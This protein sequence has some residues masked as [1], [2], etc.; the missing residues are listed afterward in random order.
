MVRQPC[1]VCNAVQIYK[2]VYHET[3]TSNGSIVLLMAILS[4]KPKACSRQAGERG[5][6]REKYPHALARSVLSFGVLDGPGQEPCQRCN[7]FFHPCL[8]DGANVLQ[9]AVIVVS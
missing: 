3:F 9:T 6:K 2:N 8:V 4:L 7:G 5:V 1:A